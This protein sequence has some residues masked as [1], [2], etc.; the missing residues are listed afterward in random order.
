MR[1]WA[2]REAAIL[3]RGRLQIRA[4]HR[5]CADAEIPRL[6]ATARPAMLRPCRS[7][8]ASPMPCPP[9]PTAKRCRR[10][11]TSC[12]APPETSVGF[13]HRGDRAWG[14]DGQG[15]RRGDARRGDRLPPRLHHSAEAK[16]RTPP[17][18]STSPGRMWRGLMP[19]PARSG[20]MFDG[21]SKVLV[22]VMEGLFQISVADG[23]YHPN[24][25][26]FL[27]RGRPNLRLGEPLLSLA[28]RDALCPMRR[29]TPMT[30]WASRPA[31]AWTR[32]GRRGSRR[33]ATATPTG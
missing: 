31:P 13:H 17:G 27:P 22:D 28:V 29:A 2:M 5:P 10:S 19:M 11:S 1:A 30:C 6:T 7:G 21:D 16:R 4:L 23:P 14:Q 33:C 15:R 32:R 12:A 9:S 18:S 26:A 3:P 24:E 20:A 8:P 25:E